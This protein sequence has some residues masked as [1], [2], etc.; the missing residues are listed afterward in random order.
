MERDELRLFIIEN[1]LEEGN[2]FKAIKSG[3]QGMFRKKGLTIPKGG[4][5]KVRDAV[6]R[7]KTLS[8]EIHTSNINNI[9]RITQGK[10]LSGQTLVNARASNIA[11]NQKIKDLGTKAGRR[12]HLRWEVARGGQPVSHDVLTTQRR[13]TFKPRDLNKYERPHPYLY[14]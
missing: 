2:P 7:M 1:Y 4:S 6:N 9:N 11:A 3:I 13:V 5:G 14:T 12:G 10:P 8:G